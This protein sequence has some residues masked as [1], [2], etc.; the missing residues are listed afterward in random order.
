[1][2]GGHDIPKWTTFAPASASAIAQ[3][4][5]NPFPAPVT[6]AVLFFRSIF[7]KLR[8]FLFSHSVA[9]GLSLTPPTANLVLNLLVIAAK[10]AIAKSTNFSEIS[11]NNPTH[12]QLWH[13]DFDDY[14]PQIKVIIALD[15]MNKERF[16]SIDLII[17]NFYPFQ[18]TV[19]DSKN[20]NKIIENIDVGGPTM[21][22]IA[23]KCPHINFN[24]V[25]INQEIVDDPSKI[26]QDPENS[27]WFFKLKIKDRSEMDSL[28]NKDDY[29]K[30]A[31]ENNT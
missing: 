19:I 3:A 20:P 29:D 15:K 18:R 10:E 26:N 23:N 4:F 9:T 25:D 7:L 13:R 28:M 1:M 27:A 22:V 21:A 17:V 30:F 6:R 31:K 16:S 2:I 12:A 11:S 8:L 5:P 14:Y 24:V